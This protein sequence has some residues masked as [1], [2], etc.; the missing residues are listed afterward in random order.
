MARQSFNSFKELLVKKD[1]AQEG[2]REVRYDVLTKIF[3][4]VQKDIVLNNIKHFTDEDQSAISSLFKLEQFSSQDTKLSNGEYE[5]L[6]RDQLK[7]ISDKSKLLLID[8]LEEEARDA[9]KENKRLE[10]LAE[11]FHPKDAGEEKEDLARRIAELKKDIIDIELTLMTLES[12]GQ[13]T[14]DRFVKMN[15]ARERRRQ[16]VQRLEKQLTAVTKKVQAQ[17]KKSKE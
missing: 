9:V 7:G 5:A 16:L 3:R 2:A 8:L 14:S 11:K 12:E 15:N 17:S 6:V 4:F 10:K 1:L 13:E